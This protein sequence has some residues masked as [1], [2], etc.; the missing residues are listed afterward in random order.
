MDS[1]SAH[2]IALVSKLGGFVSGMNPLPVTIDKLA[3]WLSCTPRNVKIILRRLEEM[4]LIEWEAGRGRGHV[5]RLTFLRSPDD[6]LTAC[7]EEFL[8]QRRIKEA[9]DFIGDPA[10]HEQLKD[11]LW[12]RLNLEMGIQRENVTPSGCDILQTIRYRRL[13]K[14]D[15]AF[16]FT[17]FEAYL[18]GQI[19]STL[20]VYDAE[21]RTFKPGLA[22]LWECNEEYS[23]WTFYL[24]KGVRFHHGRQMTA[25]DVRYTMERLFAVNSPGLWQYADIE[26]IETEG[27]T[28][29][30]FCLKKPNLFFLHSLGCFHMSIL[31]YDV[32]LSASGELIGTG[33][34]QI[35][36]KNADVLELTAFDSYFGYRPL[37]DQV[38]IWFIPDTGSSERRYQLTGDNRLNSPVSPSETSLDYMSV[39]CRYI[40]FNFKK[41]GIQQNA[42]FRK[43]MRLIYD[44]N[45]LLQ[46]LGGSRMAPAASF[47]P[48]KS[49]QIEAI[50]GTLEEAKA[51]LQASGY[52]GEEIRLGRKNL[53]EEREEAEWLQQRC[54]SIGLNLSV[55]EFDYV[56]IKSTVERA[57][58]V[59]AEETLEEDWEWGMI[60]Y[61]KYTYN[62]VHHY[63]N[64][65]QIAV[66]DQAL[67]HFT[68]L[69]KEERSLLLDRIERILRDNNWLLHGCHLNKKAHY[70]QSLQGLTTANFGYLDFS[71]LWIKNV[72]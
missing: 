62:A 52:Q 69:P 26:R 23:C 56:E 16:V 29:I 36:K 35:S 39:G 67:E 65:Q 47:L 17:A 11:S 2:Y 18:L 15:P 54:A 42:L 10:V 72:Q 45:A 70:N 34:F 64:E 66:F 7:F 25:K 31:P 20:V 12:N 38:L 53:V 49:K 43:A 41:E 3:E 22:H 8:A 59:I 14:L 44:R 24:R 58:M 60:N 46:V 9:I 5:S 27:D 33:P 68:Q 30:R 19:C 13:E 63:L 57:D 1:Y 28:C 61:F 37:L 50:S 40:L 4:K 6:V 55:C 32:D 51:L 48:W 71:K 21:Q